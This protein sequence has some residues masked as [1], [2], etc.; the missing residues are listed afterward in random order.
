[1]RFRGIPLRQACGVMT[2]WVLP[3]EP[4]LC[5]TQVTASDV[6]MA[7]GGGYIVVARVTYGSASHAPRNLPC[8]SLDRPLA[9]GY[10]IRCTRRFAGSFRTLPRE[11]IKETPAYHHLS[12]TPTLW[13]G[14]V[15][16][17]WMLFQSLSLEE[18]PAKCVIVL[19]K[20][21]VPILL[22]FFTIHYSPYIWTWCCAIIQRIKSHAKVM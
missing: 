1:M 9:L 6:D 19:D 2:A 22:W 17:F 18:F 10:C 11:H 15:L 14:S 12:G 16:I 3:L 5:Q 13:R 21:V 20:R 8:V 7:V 4:R